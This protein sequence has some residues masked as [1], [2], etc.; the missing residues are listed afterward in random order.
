VSSLL[1]SIGKVIARRTVRDEAPVPYVSSTSN[2]AW[3]GGAS[4]GSAESSMILYSS[5]GTLFAIVS[6]ES[7]SVARLKWHLYRSAPSGKPEDR[8]EVTTHPA[9]TVLNRPNDF[10]S[11]Q[12][13]FETG[14][15]HV[16]LA[17]YAFW[18]VGRNPMFPTVPL[19][20][21]P[22]RPDKMTPITHPTEF[23]VG[24]MYRGP[25]G[26]KIPL[27]AEDVLMVRMPDPAD[28]YLGAGPVQS[29]RTDAEATR[30]ISEW[31][32]NFFRNSAEP[33]GVVEFADM[34]DDTEFNTIQ[35][36]W[37]EQHQGTA[38]AH[39]VAILEKGKWVERKYTQRDMEF[40][41][42]RSVSSDVI[43]EAFAFPKFM[44]GN[45][46]D[47]NRASADASERFF[48]EYHTVTRA[49]RWKG[50]LNN[51]YLPLFGPLGVGYEFDYDSPVK[52]DSEQENQERDSKVKAFV[53][54][55]NAGVPAA[56]ACAYLGLPEFNVAASTA[57]TVTPA[58]TAAAVAEMIQKIYVGVDTV[59]T[60][61]EAREVLVAAGAPLDLTLP[62]PEKAP[63]PSFGADPAADPAAARH[64]HRVLAQ[65]DPGPAG[66]VD[67]GPVQED[68]QRRLDTLLARWKD[69]T[70]AQ[71]DEIRMQVMAAVETHDVSALQHLSVS[72]TEASQILAVTMAAI[73][74]DG[75]MS[76]VVEARK[77]GVH[78][79]RGHADQGELSAVA[80][81]VA[82]LLA[83]GLTN[84]AARE[85]IRNYSPRSLAA[86]VANAVV[87]HLQGLSDAFLHDNLGGALSR[88]QMA[89]RMATFKQAP[90]ASLYSAEVL[91]SHICS[92]CSKVAG[93]FLGLSTDTSQVDL[94]YP[95][96]Q[97][98][99]CLGGI[100]C[101]GQ[102]VAV[103][104][105][106]TTEDG[107]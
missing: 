78:A 19:E 1:S 2:V 88:A 56:D 90:E 101:R 18:V 58:A 65:V 72:T 16:D 100:R 42:L 80:V 104:R 47:A 76:A 23:L 22:V 85:A 84:A 53:D 95:N 4:N 86:A 70:A 24:W 79:P 66:D 71:I 92:E 62:E 26:E 14:Q 107:Q 17:G 98:V 91:D 11:R 7:V 40:S 64:R 43:R 30:Y 60:W 12:E 38:N 87:A 63:A 68:W 32:R 13:L 15:Q 8:I 9:L 34:L 35:R 29:I 83:Q 21:W 49:D 6:M 93:K 106:E 45:T 54:L 82:I 33:G 36:R 59:V 41:T 3:P 5:V 67:L 105:T 51:D 61:Q 55:L 99:H 37:R 74:E 102:V 25:N 39:R 94:T 57:G 89:G 81:T 20:L 27:R 10:Y 69:I 75:S 44:I 96:G 50:L 77:Q 48:A 52:D 28:P 97:Y 73:A 46:E 31:N 103:W